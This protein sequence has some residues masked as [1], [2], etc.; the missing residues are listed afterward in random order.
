MRGFRAAIAEYRSTG[1]WTRAQIADIGLSI[2]ALAGAPRSSI[3]SFSHVQNSSLRGV[4]ALAQSEQISLTTLEQLLPRIAEGDL[5][6]FED[7]YDATSRRLFAIAYRILRDESVAQ[8]A[9]QEAY[10]NVWRRAK[11]YDPARGSPI[12]WMSVIVRNVALNMIRADRPTEPI[13]DLDIPVAPVDPPDSRLGQCL[14]RLPEDQGN[15]ILLTYTYGLTHSELAEHLSVPL[16][17]AKSWVR[18]G[19][20]ALKECMQR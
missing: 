5:A 15:A 2:E 6:A 9:T 20:L 18:R 16:G 8:D 17:T 4:V 13:D 12:G 3:I 14:K 1:F 11:L 7:L 19:M 10:V